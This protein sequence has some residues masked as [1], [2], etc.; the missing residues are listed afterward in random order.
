MTSRKGLI[1]SVAA[2]ALSASLAGCSSATPGGDEPAPAASAQPPAG[3]AP[4]VTLAAFTDADLSAGQ[5][6]LAARLYP[7]LVAQS[8]ESDNL[9]ISP[10]PLA[11]GIGLTVSGARGTTETELRDVLGWKAGEERGVAAYNT[12][13]MATGDARVALSVAN[14]IWLRQDLAVEP[15]YMAAA[16][17]QFGATAQRLDFANDASGAAKA[18]NDWASKET[19]GRIPSIIQPGALDATTAA[20]LTNAVWFKA[21]WMAAFDKAGPLTFR[22]ADGGK[23]VLPGMTRTAPIAYRADAEGQTAVLP[24]GANDR[25][26]AEVFLPRDAA[27][28][29][30][31]ERELSP[32]DFRTVAQ[33]G[34]G[35]FA[36]ADLPKADLELTMP[37]FE[38]KFTGS[39]ARPLQNAGL[40]CAFADGCA[41]FSGMTKNDVMI[42]DVI[43]AT[44]LRVDDKGTEA[45]AV[46]TVIMV[47]S[48]APIHRGPVMIVD[49]P[50]IMA[51][52]DRQTG[53]LLF[54]GRIAAPDPAPQ[55]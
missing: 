11:E 46:T 54:F 14:A 19:R 36:V 3:S 13:L 31:W 53:A 51:L 15:A 6:R 41:D 38:A 34:T 24:Y 33:G 9:F 47:E 43:H 22:L 44:F 10:L 8:G 16:R 20:I 30:K 28:L 35:R 50:F 49:R 39:L 7:A 32:A 37:R 12:A 26:V 48:S 18:I 27:T 21:Q 45:A 23:R 42:S 4:A 29:A 1:V 2:F 17:D 5:E 55:G 25:F 40:R 52:R